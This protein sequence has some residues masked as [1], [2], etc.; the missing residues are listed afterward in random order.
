MKEIC[1]ITLATAD[2]DTIYSIREFS[3]KYLHRIGML[4]RTDRSYPESGWNTPATGCDYEVYLMIRLSKSADSGMDL[5]KE[6]RRFLGLLLKRFGDIRD[7]SIEF[8]V[9]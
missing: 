8:S 6:C 9:D 5:R 7:S 4:C 3:V 2:E 1:Y